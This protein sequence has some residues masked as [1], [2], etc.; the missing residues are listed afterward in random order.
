MPSAACNAPTAI[1]PQDSHGNGFIYGE[2]ANAIEIGCRDCHGTAR[3]YA[4]LRTSGPAA[5]PRGTNLELIRNEDGR[6]RFEW[7]E[8]DGR[9]VLIQRS[10]VDPNLEWEVSQVRDSVDREPAR[11]ATARGDQRDPGPLLQHRSARAKLMSR[12]GAETGRYAFGDGVPDGELAHPDERDGLLHLPP[13]SWTTS[14]AGCHLPIEANNRTTIHHY[15]GERDPQ[16]RDLQSA[17]RA[18]RDVPARPAPDHQGQYH[19][20]D[21]LDLGAGPVLDQHQPRA[22]LRPAAADLRRRASRARPSRRISRTPCARTETKTCT[23]CHVSRGQ[24]QQ[25]DHG[26]AA[27]A[28]APTS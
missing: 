27:A 8:R 10:I 1:S 25:C 16:L 12:S 20:P 18:R 28:R 14:C 22:D 3:E 19:R 6:R 11:P 17:G 23:D 9:R 26:A 5:P 24:R 4:N 21:P 7:I 13:V 2:V 15:E